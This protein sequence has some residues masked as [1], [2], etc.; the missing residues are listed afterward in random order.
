MSRNKKTASRELL[1][2]QLDTIAG[3]IAR[4]GVYVVTKQTPGYCVQEYLSN[5]QTVTGIPD[6]HTAQKLC[7]RYNQGKPLS[8]NQLKKFNVLLNQYHK[9]KTDLL[10]F[11]YTLRNSRDSV[12]LATTTF[13]YEKT[14]GIL[15]RLTDQI[16]KL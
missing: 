16:E 9:N 15:G 5:K 14:G 10:F 11:E 8:N 7:D 2:Y 6:I 12:L 1:V 13:R 4:R 3:N